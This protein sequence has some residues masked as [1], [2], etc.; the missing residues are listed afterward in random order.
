ME[1]G[2]NDRNYDKNEKN[3]K[4]KNAKCHDDTCPVDM[5]EGVN[6][7]NDDKKGMYD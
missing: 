1:E 5:E 7:L 3:D 2:V 4:K 6:N